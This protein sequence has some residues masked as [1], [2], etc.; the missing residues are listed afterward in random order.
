MTNQET[1][2]VTTENLPTTEA[3][4][5][6]VARPENYDPY[7]AYGD[8][9]SGGATNILKFKKGTY[10]AGPDEVEVPIGTQLVANPPGAKIGCIRW[11][12]GHPT[13]DRMVLISEGVAPPR[14]NELGDDDQSLWET[15]DRGDP[16]DP[17][18]FTNSLP[19]KDPKTGEEYLFSTSSKGGIRALGKFL[20]A[21]GVEYRQKPGR[22]PVIELQ[23]DDYAHPNKSYGRIDV[24]V[25]PLV[26][27][28]DEAELV[29]AEKAGDEPKKT[30][31]ATK[32]TSKS[33][34]GH[35]TKF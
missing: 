33:G 5:G 16:R 3:S 6:A 27:W 25:L 12:D 15:D 28:V 26:N 21:Y 2:K 23:A 34:A 14:R 9:A 29:E 31:D 7:V 30:A 18:Q 24:P 8:Q 1:K 32:P 13:E 22:L 4:G 35:P 17:W 10:Y 19:L 11:E 20:K